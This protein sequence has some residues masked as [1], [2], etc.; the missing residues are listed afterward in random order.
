MKKSSRLS[1]ALHALVHLEAQP[2]KH[3]TSTAL[4]SCL[5]T[6]PVVVRRILGE[7]REAR[8]VAASKGPS[9]GWMLARPAEDITVR[10]V[11]AA[12]GESLLVRT[13]SEPGDH[14]CAIVRSVDAVM[15]DVLADAEA[16][17][18]ER[19]AQLRISDLARQTHGARIPQ[20]G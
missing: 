8:L 7:L 14:G 9:G 17:L 13:Q 6:N 3:L 19:L 11:Y 20:L 16:L 18:A 15:K 5:L 4:A 12:M 10:E 1:L 2:D